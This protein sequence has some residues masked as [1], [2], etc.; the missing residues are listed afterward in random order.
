M[1]ADSPDLYACSLPNA[2]IRLSSKIRTIRARTPVHTV[3]F[4]KSMS[5]PEHLAANPY[6]KQHAFPRGAATG[7]KLKFKQTPEGLTIH[8]PHGAPSKR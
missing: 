7:H 8:V 4:R 6:P 3:H 5:A 2:H 1:L